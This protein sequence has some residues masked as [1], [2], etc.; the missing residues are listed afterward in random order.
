M[1]RD[2][3]KIYGEPNDPNTVL[4]N[5]L[6]NSG[7]L[8]IGDGGKKIKEFVAPNKSLIY[9]TGSGIASFDYGVANKI[10]GTDANGNLVLKDQVK[11]VIKN[12]GGTNA[13]LD[14]SGISSSEVPSG[15]KGNVDNTYGNNISLVQLS[16][17]EKGSIYNS[18]DII[19][20][21]ASQFVTPVSLL[22]AFIAVSNRSTS[23]NTDYSPTTLQLIYTESSSTELK[24][25]SISTNNDISF[26]NDNVSVPSGSTIKGIRLGW[27][28]DKVVT[29][30]TY[31]FGISAKIIY[32][33][34]GA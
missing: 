26:I 22:E 30:D 31:Y 19:W 29:S 9:G 25:T 20:P 34:G 8:I 18:L 10:I 13:P 23:V 27:V 24:Y 17:N 7:N 4:A 14:F 28:S 3:T 2:K 16:P 1:I 15:F 33:E 12:F 32:T 5:G 11:T 6:L 21:L